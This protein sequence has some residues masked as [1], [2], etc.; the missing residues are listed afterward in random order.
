MNKS[1]NNQA[2]PVALLN[3]V[4][5]KIVW[6]QL[7]QAIIVFAV[8]Y[9]ALIVTYERTALNL[10]FTDAV[11]GTIGKVGA[12]WTNKSYTAFYYLNTPDEGRYDRVKLNTVPFGT[13]VTDLNEGKV[14]PKVVSFKLNTLCYYPVAFGLALAL[15]MPLGVLK[16]LYLL[17]L[18]IVGLIVIIWVKFMVFL[19]HRVPVI[20]GEVSEVA[21]INQMLNAH[22]GM[23]TMLIFLLVLG[24]AA[25]LGSRP[26]TKS[27]HA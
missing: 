1:S 13:T 12:K 21:L 17:G 6:K 14:K 26:V 4:F 27:K 7:L 3:P 9:A 15:A 22:A 25:W 8:A 16:K 11:L 19:M 18:V 2:K 24:T 5:G 20:N 10:S 23:S